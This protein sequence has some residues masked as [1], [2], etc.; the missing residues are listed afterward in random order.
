MDNN[1]L[2]K[3]EDFLT[4]LKPLKRFARKKKLEE[5]VL[6]RE[7]DDLYISLIGIA[8]SANWNLGNL[9]WIGYGKE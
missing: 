7:G 1:V 6:S 9:S 8:T 5:A 4:M 3:R 2:I